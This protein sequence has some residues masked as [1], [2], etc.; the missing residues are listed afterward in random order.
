MRWLD[1]VCRPLSYWASRN[2]ASYPAITEANAY[3]LYSCRIPIVFP[4]RSPSR[5]LFGAIV[6]MLIGERRAL[7]FVVISLAAFSHWV[8]GNMISHDGHLWTEVDKHLIMLALSEIGGHR[9]AS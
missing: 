3:D 9:D 4:A 7:A 5:W 2:C 6:A 1:V 8:L